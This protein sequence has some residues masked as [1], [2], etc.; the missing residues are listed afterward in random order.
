MRQGFL[1]LIACFVYFTILPRVALSISLIWEP[2]KS[3]CLN[4]NNL[5][6]I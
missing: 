1:G 3:F 5:F 2:R 6:L 4:S